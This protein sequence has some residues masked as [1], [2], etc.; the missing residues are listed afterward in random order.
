MNVNKYYQL[1][2]LDKIVNQLKKHVRLE[3][4]KQL[5]EEIVLM[6]SLE[7]VSRTLDEVDEATTILF[8]YGRL[9]LYFTTKVDNLVKKVSKSGVLDEME[10][11]DISRLLDSVR[12]NILMVEQLKDQDIEAP[13]FFKYIA[14]LIYPKELNLEIKKI[15][16]PYGEVLDTASGE[17]KQIRRKLQD[18]EKSIQNK[19][20]ELIQ[21]NQSK[22]SSALVSLRNGRY[23]LPV[24]HDYKNQVKG[25]LHDQSAS[26]ETVFIEP[27]IVVE[28]SNQL[29][30][31]K[32]QEKQEIFR[33]LKQISAKIA[34]EKESLFADYKLLA[35]LDMI[36][37]KAAYSIELDGV[38]PEVNTDGIV[39]L[40]HAKHPLLNVEKVVRN[41]ISIGKSYQ[42]MI[43]TGPNTG[44]KTVLLKTIGLLS[45]MTKMGLLIPVAK[46]SKMMLF[47]QVFADIGDEQSIDQNLSTFSSHMTNIIK[48][49]NQVT[50]RSLV[51]LDELG[52]G[53]DPSEGSSLAIAMIE[54]LLDKECLVI[55][56]SHYSELKVHA[57]QSDRLINASVEF[58]LETLAPTYRLLIGVPGQSNALNI[59]KRLGLQTEIIQRAEAYSFHKDDDLKTV[60]NKLI[61]Q[62]HELEE[63]LVL[64]E[65]TMKENLILQETLHQEIKE[66]KEKRNEILQKASVEA[67]KVILHK[68]K[69]I[70]NLLEELKQ[71]DNVKL[72][73]I[74]DAKYRLKQIAKE[75]NIDNNLQEEVE[76]ME[77]DR[78]YV[79]T[80]QA[81]GVLL[82]L[83]RSNKAEVQMGNATIKVDKDV[84]KKATEQKSVTQKQQ[85]AREPKQIIMKQVSMQLDLRGERYEE[86]KIKLEKYFDDALLAGLEVITIIHGYGSGAIRSVVQEFVKNHPHIE[87]T[88][89]GGSGEGGMGST[90]IKLKK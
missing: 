74:T 29:V 10:L 70:Q 55:G 54:Y 75:E 72:H 13:L 60:L 42:G 7:E 64:Q 86:A 46:G 85:V 9:V 1:L 57:F 50:N 33:I 31:F 41:T 67:K 48:I 76:L 5:L 28:L 6:D 39:E 30:T 53:T 88:R 59:A 52:S 80:Y 71:K 27:S 78:V 89:Y 43:I 66:T 32:E 63:K 79:Q 49:M 40:I 16:T 38:K 35:Y 11:L 26:G 84:L 23:V 45:L 14:E 18:T 8:R 3:E 73:E 81:Y 36:F 58:N 2:E 82:K 20:Q 77:G 21:K 25:I 61:D 17:I 90:V 12:D 87:S 47:D 51:V 24:K 37:G 4:N 44:G 15:I 83:L 69:E 19:L 56:T 34:E 62:S 65:K 22:L 68:S